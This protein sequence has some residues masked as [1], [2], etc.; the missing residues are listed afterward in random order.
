MVLCPHKGTTHA[1]KVSRESDI[2]T[3]G[4]S[5]VA[6]FKTMTWKFCENFCRSQTQRRVNALYV[7]E[8]TSHPEPPCCFFGIGMPEMQLGSA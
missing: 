6:K 3:P 4:T 7:L 5:T 2:I 8:I 1:Y